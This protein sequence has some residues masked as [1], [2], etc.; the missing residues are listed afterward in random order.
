MSCGEQKAAWLLG[1]L[2]AVVCLVV[3]Y[4]LFCVAGAGGSRVI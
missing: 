1:L 2:L 3:N 4:L